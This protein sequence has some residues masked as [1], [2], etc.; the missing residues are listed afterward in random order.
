MFR[1]SRGEK[2]YGDGCECNLSPV[3]K[4][5]AENIGKR[6]KCP[7]VVSPGL[8]FD[9]NIAFICLFQIFQRLQREIGHSMERTEE[10]FKKKSRQGWKRTQ[11]TDL[12]D[13]PRQET[14][15]T[16]THR[17]TNPIDTAS[18]LNTSAV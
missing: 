2:T 1:E 9:A 18:G 6:V 17:G 14:I 13:F 10:R 15:L 5:Y 16:K 3:F 7:L 8:Y 11:T 4:L 12:I